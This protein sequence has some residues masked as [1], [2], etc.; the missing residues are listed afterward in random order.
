M[1]FRYFC[2]TNYTTIFT[3]CRNRSFIYKIMCLR[4]QKPKLWNHIFNILPILLYQR[5]SVAPHLH[6]SPLHSRGGGG[7]FNGRCYHIVKNDHGQSVS[8]TP[9]THPDSRPDEL[10]VAL[11]L[12]PLLHQ[13]PRSIP[14]RIPPKPA[15][16]IV[17]RGDR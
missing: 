14:Q 1:I 11:L 15:T 7:V 8:R 13:A 12:Q 3:F 17:Q 9:V 10:H 5:P 4:S 16:E 2:F 6:A